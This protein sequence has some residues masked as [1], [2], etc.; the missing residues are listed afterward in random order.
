MGG[1]VNITMPILWALGGIVALL[2]VASIA[3]AALKATRPDSSF[4]EVGL[5]VRTWWVMVAVFAAALV[6]HPGATIAMFLVISFLALKEYLT[7]I[8]TR[9]A[10][11][12]VLFWAYISIPIQ[13]WWVATGWY[14]MFVLWIPLYMFLLIPLRLVLIGDTRDYLR[15]AA[16]IHWGLMLTVFSLSHVPAFLFLHYRE[17]VV[18][19]GGAAGLILFAVVLTQ[20]NDVFQYL[21]GKSIGRTKAVPKVS[22]GKTVEG[23]VGGAATTLVLA[24]LVA[25]VLTPL[26]LTHSILAGLIFGLGGFIGDV[27]ISALKRD[28]GVKDSGALLPGHGGMLD[29]IDSLMFTA[30]IFF[31]YV[32]YLYGSPLATTAIMPGNS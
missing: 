26:S 23:L 22:P 3:V 24:V 2:V 9:R 13:Y 16:T 17:G 27:T 15:S 21:W 10:D 6:I 29:R 12:R 19:P 28:L 4:E 8:P 25:P 1:F 20:A 18:L 11:R 32:R 7:L 5:R 30:P 31:H 14:G